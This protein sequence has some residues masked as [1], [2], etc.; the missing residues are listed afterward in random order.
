[1]LP[2][3]PGLFST[4]AVCLSRTCSPSAISRPTT[5]LE[6]PGVNGMMMRI[7]LLGKPCA[8]ADEKLAG[9]MAIAIA[10]AASSRVMLTPFGARGGEMPVCAVT[11]FK[12]SHCPR[13]GPN[14]RLA[15]SQPPHLAAIHVD[16]R[17]VQPAPARR[18][19]EGDETGDI[20]R[21]AEAGDADILAVPFAHRRLVLAGALHVGLDAPP[22]ALGLDIARVNAVHLHAVGLAEMGQCLAERGTGG[23]H[24]AADGETG[25]RHP[26]AG[27]SDGDERAAAL[28]QQRPGSAR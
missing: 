10:Q 8:K 15:T 16:G 4:I 19:D 5:S 20:S 27:P 22:E 25:G 2:P 24:R 11:L 7:V 14:T 21:R 23:V 18:R 3:P 17:A 26:A 13:D 1:M 12:G 9:E 6:P 28:L